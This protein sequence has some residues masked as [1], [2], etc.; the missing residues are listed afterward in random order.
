LCRIEDEVRSTTV[1]LHQVRAVRAVRSFE[2]ACGWFVIE[3]GWG[4]R[5]AVKAKQ[6]YQRIS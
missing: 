4:A 1:P 3:D 5:V 2:N 6:S